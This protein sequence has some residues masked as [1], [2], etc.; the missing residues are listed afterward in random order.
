MELLEES[1]AADGVLKKWIS[2]IMLCVT[3][4]SYSVSF[5]GSQVRPIISKRGLRQGDPLSPYLFLICVEGLSL[6]LRD[7]ANDGR[8]SGCKIH[9]YAP[10]V[11]HLLFADDS[12]LFCKASME[13]ARVIKEIL[14]RYE[15][16]SGQAI[17][18][19]KSGIFFSSNVRM[20]KQQEI[21]K[22]V[23]SAQ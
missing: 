1:V 20:D 12:F 2:W 13:E 11:T 18:F 9:E 15:V 17:N 16:S 6:S 3:T 22:S 19:Q 5:N 14:Q 10:A 7:A 21:K 23:R 8:V 4:I